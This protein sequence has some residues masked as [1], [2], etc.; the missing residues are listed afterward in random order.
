MVVFHLEVKQTHKCIGEY[1]LELRGGV[2]VGK[3]KECALLADSQRV[4]IRP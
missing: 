4:A 2:D 1:E 3:R